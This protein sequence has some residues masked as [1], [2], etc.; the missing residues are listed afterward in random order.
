LKRKHRQIPGR[1]V[2]LE[3]SEKGGVHPERGG[4]DGGKGEFAS[5]RG[6]PVYA[7]GGFFRDRERS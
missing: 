5:R 6:K 3:I 7:E 1:K 4:I 2:E